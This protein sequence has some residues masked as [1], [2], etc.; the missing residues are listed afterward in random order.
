VSPHRLVRAATAI[1]LLALST[2]AATSAAQAT[3]VDSATTAPSPSASPSAS[4]GAA[5]PASPNK[6]TF[7]IGTATKGRLDRRQGIQLVEA[8]GSVAY[9][10]VAVVNQAFVPLVLEVYAVDVFNDVNGNLQPQVAAVK[11]T[12]AGSW[13]TLANPGGKRT[14]TVPA[15]GTVV[16]PVTVRVPKNAPV[17]DH[18]AGIMVSLTAKGQGSGDKPATV[19]LE[20]RVG[21]RVSVRVAGQLKPEL[22]I[23]GLLAR[24][25]GSLNPFGKGTAQISYVVTNTGNIKLGARQ[26]VTIHS[27]IGS[28]APNVAVADVPVLLPG[29]SATITLQVPDVLPLVFL[30][31]DVTVIPAAAVGDADP[32][33]AIATAST[34]FWA[35]P[36]TLLALMIALGLMIAWW[37]RRMR[38]R[39]PSEPGRREMSGATPEQNFASANSSA[40][41]VA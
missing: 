2:L 18:L 28:A 7:G 6:V 27:L 5:Q 31:A 8:R 34:H 33:L 24:Y 21:L 23:S 9:D 39:T 36:W 1:G 35:I 14:I 25:T 26:E 37:V 4:A 13:V 38:R 17:G 16:I 22:T 29:G 3:T 32:A 12:D 40:G 41:G 20:Q 10:A 11:A 19:D 30:T 15:K